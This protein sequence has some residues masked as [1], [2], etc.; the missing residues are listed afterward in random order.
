M[1]QRSP[2][3][4]YD[5][6]LATIETELESRRRTS[7][8]L[9]RWRGAAFFPALV[10]AIATSQEAMPSVIGYPLAGVLFSGF[11]FLAGRHEQIERE[12]GALAE[13]KQ[14]YQQHLARLD[15]N[16]HRLPNIPLHE[17]GDAA[18]VAVARDLDLFGTRSLFQWLSLTQT[19]LGRE[20]L[21]AWLL[22]PAPVAEIKKRQVA[23][24]ELSKEV[25]TREEVQL[26][27]RLLSLSPHGPQAFLGWSE[28]SSWLAARRW[29]SIYAWLVA[30]VLVAAAAAAA[31]GSLSP[32]LAVV[33]GVTILI[34]LIVN[35]TVV[36]NIHKRFDSVASR[37]NEVAQ[38]RSLIQMVTNLPDTAPKFKELKLQIKQEGHDP[39]LALDDLGRRVAWAS[40]RRSPIWGLPYL[41][42]QLFLVW[43]V[44]VLRRLEVWQR[45]HGQQARAWFDTLADF[46]ALV[47]LSGLAHDEPTWCFPQIDET[48]DCFQA[49]ELGHP[50]LSSNER[51]T[52]DVTIGPRDS[53]LLVTGSN[54]SGK[55]TLL[56]SVGVNAILALS[57]GP[58]CAKQCRLP[59]LRVATSMRVGDSLADGVSF[60]MAELQRLKQVVDEA[61]QNRSDKSMLLYL[62]DEILLGTNSS[63]RHIAVVQ[64]VR[65][66]LKAG[67]I[68]AIS[69]HDLDLAESPDLVDHCHPV[70][71]RERIESIDG[72]QKMTFDYRMREG[73]ATTTNALML[74]EMVGLSAPD[75]NE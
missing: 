28:E 67:A 47:S 38:Y 17:C 45:Q 48:A 74:L 51:V 11:L 26:R 16:F 42:A 20:R 49:D 2:R 53:F 63:E 5:Q 35:V 72:E 13:K 37:Q 39:L 59:L 14:I 36:P 57:G 27:G 66:L 31:I 69:T 19:A 54:M 3:D 60:Y 65:H 24:Q 40:A 4:F 33:L 52:N 55:S 73:V 34:N 21:A 46:E 25:D 6:R 43:D 8:R 71:F 12:R 75:T 18:D 22:T 32:L 10:L 68:G 9:S 58:V 29:L 62:L 41:V 23:I 61:K 50:L 70:H 64:V 15:R 1:T 7:E 30:G 56:R 44:H